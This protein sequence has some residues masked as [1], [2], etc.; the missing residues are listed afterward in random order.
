MDHDD[1]FRKYTDVTRVE[2]VWAHLMEMFGDI[3][4]IECSLYRAMVSCRSPNPSLRLSWS[5][6]ARDMSY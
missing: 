2:S 5:W 4:M 6:Y 1:M 3:W